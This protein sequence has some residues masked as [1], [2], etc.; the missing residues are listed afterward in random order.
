MPGCVLYV[1]LDALV[2]AAGAGG[3]ATLAF[4]L[5]ANPSLLDMPFFVQAVQLDPGANP[6]GLVLSDAGAGVI[7]GR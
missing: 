4:P 6:M 3:M 1:S 2:S 5:G 7:G